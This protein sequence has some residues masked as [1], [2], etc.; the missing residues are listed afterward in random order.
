VNVIKILLLFMTAILWAAPE[1]HWTTLDRNRIHYQVSGHGTK[2]IVFV[3]GWT[4]DASFWS[5]QV[6]VFDKRYR[7][8]ALDLP[9][10]GQSDA[11]RVPYTMDLFANAVDAVLKDARVDSA[12]LVGHSMGAPV[13][14]QY[15]A[16]HPDGIAGLVL[17]DGAVYAN[18]GEEGIVRKKER[19]TAFLASLRGPDYRTNASKFIDTMF[20]EETRP[21]LREEIR[22]KMLST[23][24][25]VAFSA[26][27][28]MIA[29][30]VWLD[31][32]LALPVLAINA[33]KEKTPTNRNERLFAS[34]FTTSNIMNGPAWDIS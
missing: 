32:P 25:H 1:D 27:Q 21:E 23:P 22:V 2:A 8:I 14:R 15:L 10:H 5:R 24:P 3:H 12:V 20:V 29:S 31:K 17:A 4:C 34:Q 19:T 26:M 9:G 16:A 28:N 6:P 30:R 33:V 13:L 11:P 18:E 7:V